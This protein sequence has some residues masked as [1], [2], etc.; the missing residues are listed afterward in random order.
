MLSCSF[1]LENSNTTLVKVKSNLSAKLFCTFIYSNT[2]LVKV[3]FSIYIQLNM[4]A[5]LFKYNTC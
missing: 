2:T 4:V 1:L 5:Y 3:K